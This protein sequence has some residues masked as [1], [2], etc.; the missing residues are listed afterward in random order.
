MKYD[1]NLNGSR[2][3]VEIDDDRVRLVSKDAAAKE[4][5]VFHADELPD[6]DFGGEQ[7]SEGKKILAQLPGTVISVTVS[8]GQHIAKG[9]T[10]F[11]IESMKM[12]NAITAQQDCIISDIL[13][14]Q[15]DSVQKNQALA[16]LDIA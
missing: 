5:T 1:I 10:V 7:A 6:F 4:T 9:D 11:V 13:V 2:Y 12:E 14:Q 3:I 15:G 8:K 16:I